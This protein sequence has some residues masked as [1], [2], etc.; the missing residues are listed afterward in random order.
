MTNNSN[1]IQLEYENHPD[2]IFQQIPYSIGSDKI[3][4]FNN[5]YQKIANNSTSGRKHYKKN[6]Q[7][8][9]YQLEDIFIDFKEQVSDKYEKIFLDELENYLN[10]I[11]KEE[12]CFYQGINK[13]KEFKNTGLNTFKKLKSERHFF[14]TLDDKP[15]SEIYDLCSD[16]ISIFRERAAEGK[17]TR[18]NLSINSGKNIA[19]ISKILNQEFSKQGVL[20]GLRGYMGS[21]Y[22]VGGLAVEL[23][24]S[25]SDWWKNTNNN[26]S[27]PK[28]MYAHFDESKRYPK[29][30]V[31]LSDVSKKN[32]PTSCYPK[33]YEDL[34]LNALQE[35][36]G[37]VVGKVGSEEGSKLKSYY[38]RSYHQAMSSERFRQHFMKLPMKLRFN[39]HFGWD[40]LANS[41]AEKNLQSRESKMIGKRGTYIVFDGAKLLHRGGLIEEDERI[42]LQIIFIQ[43]PAFYNNIISLPRRIIAKLIRI[44]Q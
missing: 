33:A 8:L 20:E 35:L 13:E 9:T 27:P 11:L 18:D 31:Y 22:I 37:R 30:I 10:I 2:F 39:S 36:I 34:E 43:A 16:D 38:D 42:A 32:G 41:H 12:I 15:I 14:G 44:L 4:A 1:L 3:S 26:V 7:I 19:K 40:V 25:N 29:A 5:T 28:T 17:L 23:S 21:G 24:A 6:I